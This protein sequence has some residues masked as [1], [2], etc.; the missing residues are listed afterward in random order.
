MKTLNVALVALGL[1]MAP[2]VPAAVPD[3]AHDFDWEIGIWKT[4]VKRLVHPLTGSSTWAEYDGTSAIRKIW[5]GKANMVELEVDGPAG[6]LELA[7]WRLY[8][9]DS[10]Q[11]SL[12]VASSRGGGIGVPTVGGFKDGRAEFYDH[13]T[14]AGKPIVVRFVI[15][16]IRP[17][18]AH[19]EQAFSADGG[20]TW[21][22]NWIADDTR[23]KDAAA[24]GI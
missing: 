2:A 4:H 18:S 16:D 8:D 5:G 12:N 1:A 6:H 19:F 11:W 24:S 7:S 9:P 20:K 22:M 21:E 10:H 23:L 3:G 17:D 13:E 14:W 15:S